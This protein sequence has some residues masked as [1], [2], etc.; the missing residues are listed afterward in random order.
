MKET[1][2]GFKIAEEDLKIRGP[3]DVMGTE[4]SG[5]LGFKFAN[6]TQDT[7]VLQKA[8]E[9]AINFISSEIKMSTKKESSPTPNH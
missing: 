9:A 1:N 5:Y 3:G 8:R 7:E 6:P 2:D 4:Q